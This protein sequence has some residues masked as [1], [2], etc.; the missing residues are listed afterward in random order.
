[1]H[2][3][4][5]NYMTIYSFMNVFN[6]NCITVEVVGPVTKKLILILLLCLYKLDKIACVTHIPKPK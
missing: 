1:M 6:Q 5:I 2:G 3:I 4:V